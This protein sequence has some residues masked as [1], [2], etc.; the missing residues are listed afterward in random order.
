M[1]R[2]YIYILVFVLTIILVLLNHYQEQKNIESYNVNNNFIVESMYKSIEPTSSLII[3]NTQNDNQ[4]HQYEYKIKVDKAVGA[5]RYTLND[6]EKYLVFSALGE[7]NFFLS[8]NETITIYELPTSSNYVIDQVTDVSDRYVTQINN[9]II[10]KVEGTLTLENNIEFYNKA[11]T[12]VEPVKKNPT[13]NDNYVL[14]LICLI[15][16]T[17]LIVCLKNIKIRRFE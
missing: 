17:I 7:A 15:F 12:I 8:S 6:K 1:K 2:K 3:K 10:N 11:K 13:T 16:S 9:N 4:I 14:G 5:Y